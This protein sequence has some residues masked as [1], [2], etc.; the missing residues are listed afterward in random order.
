[1]IYP[2]YMGWILVVA[3]IVALFVALLWPRSFTGIDKEKSQQVVVRQFSWSE[4]PEG[5][6]WLIYMGMV[7][8][9][10]AIIGALSIIEKMVD[11]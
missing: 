6:Q 5:V 11:K 3:G 2:S 4:I 10:A 7:F 1:M 8:L 9:F